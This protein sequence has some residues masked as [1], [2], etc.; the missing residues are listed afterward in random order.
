MKRTRFIS[1]GLVFMIFILF[2]GYV[3]AGEVK[4]GTIINKSNIDSLKGETFEGHTIASLLTEKLELMIRNY[5]MAMKIQHSKVWTPEPRYIQATEKYSKNVKYDPKTRLVTGY[6]AG[7]PFPNVSLDDPYAGDKLMYNFVYAAPVGDFSYVP[8]FTYLY[9][10]MNRG[11]ERRQEWTYQQYYLKGRLSGP[12]EGD[13]KTLKK[14]LMVALSPTDIRGLGTLK[15]MYDD[16]RVPDLW[17]YIKSVRRIRR[18]PGGAWMDPIGGT[19]LLNDDISVFDGMPPWYPKIKVLRKRWV[20]CSLHDD[21]MIWGRDPSKKMGTPEEFPNYDLKNPPYCNFF[22]KYEPREVYVIEIT[23]PKEH[24]SSK[25]ILYMDTKFPMIYHGEVY[26]RQ[27]GFW[28]FINMPARPKKAED[29]TIVL[30]KLG[31]VIVDIKR[32]HA[33]FYV[34]NN[35]GWKTNPVGANASWLS[36]EKLEEIGKG[37]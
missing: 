32:R 35:T 26:D 22:I 19:D 24:P 7:L 23:N 30:Q 31:G 12:Q 17:A 28:K 14:F 21:A 5:G 16:G 33:S 37:K 9:V 27:G 6:V 15:T 11:V 13:G 1:S 25:K 18:L 3:I 10:D 36:L 20:F 29:G 8:R 4:E 34:V 2:A